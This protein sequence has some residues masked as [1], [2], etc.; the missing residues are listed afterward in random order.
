VA[1]TKDYWRIGH[2]LVLS[3]VLSNSQL[4]EEGIDTGAHEH[5][6][7][8]VTPWRD[9]F[10]WRAVAGALFGDDPART[11]HALRRVPLPAPRPVLVLT[12]PF[13][14]FDISR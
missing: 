1:V 14:K 7:L 3:T 12:V 2:S 11:H 5:T 8:K 4:M 9:W 13:I 6:Q 10:E